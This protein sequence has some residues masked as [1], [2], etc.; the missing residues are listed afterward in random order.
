M[1]IRSGMKWPSASLHLSNPSVKLLFTLLETRQGVKFI[2]ASNTCFVCKLFLLDIFTR[3][4]RVQ[5]PKRPIWFQQVGATCHTSN[6]TSSDKIFPAIRIPIAVIH[7]GRQGLLIYQLAILSCWGIY[8]KDFTREPRWLESLK[9]IIIAK[10]NCIT[11]HISNK[12][13]GV[14]SMDDWE[15]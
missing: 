5:I 7:P 6:D 1:Y 10:T 2:S 3:N 15:N 4:S 13:I 11:R 9:Q 8:T 12:A 14:A